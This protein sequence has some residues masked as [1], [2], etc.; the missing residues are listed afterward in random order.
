[1][2]RIPPGKAI[3]SLEFHLILMNVIQ[4]E[5]PDLV[6]RVRDETT[7]GRGEDPQATPPRS[8]DDVLS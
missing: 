8:G 4:E 6:P 5:D 1:M 2:E 7:A 3:N